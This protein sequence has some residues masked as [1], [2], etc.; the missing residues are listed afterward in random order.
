M[1][2]P[3]G[4]F[5]AQERDPRGSVTLV[6][7]LARPGVADP[8]WCPWVEEVGDVGRQR[9]TAGPSEGAAAAV[10]F[11]IVV[12][13]VVFLIAAFVSVASFII[14]YEHLNAAAREGARYGA[15]SQSTVAEI[16]VRSLDAMPTGGFDVAPT[17][18]AWTQPPGSSLWVGPLT[19]AERPCN[20]ILGGEARV[21]VRVSGV[22]RSDV[23]ILS[24]LPITM[25]AQGIYRCE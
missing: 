16:R 21:R 9:S 25:T 17:L 3:P 12:P 14:Q 2:T 8:L 11:A 22:V 5:E 15:L 24:L 18:Q 7:P 20:Q 23:P 4:P 10:E 6:R 1:V 19:D 13:F